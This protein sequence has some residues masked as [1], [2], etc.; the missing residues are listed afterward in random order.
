MFYTRAVFSIEIHTDQN[1]NFLRFYVS[2]VNCIL[3]VLCLYI[4]HH[5]CPD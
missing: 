3:I 5:R 2:F 4:Y 1:G